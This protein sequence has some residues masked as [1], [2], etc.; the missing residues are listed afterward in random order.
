MSRLQTLKKMDV[1]ERKMALQRVQSTKER[2]ML[3]TL[4]DKPGEF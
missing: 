2:E 3:Q 1:Y 4:F